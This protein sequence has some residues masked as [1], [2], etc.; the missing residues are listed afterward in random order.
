MQVPLSILFTWLYLRSKGSL[1]IAVFF[2]TSIDVMGDLG[3]SGYEGTALLSGVVAGVVVL[4]LGAT[5]AAL[6]GDE[7]GG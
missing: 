5:S 1:L 7:P 4:G 2:H 3:L 6:R